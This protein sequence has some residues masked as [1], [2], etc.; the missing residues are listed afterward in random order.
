MTR[1]FASGI[2][3]P[4]PDLGRV[5][6]DGIFVVLPPADLAMVGSPLVGTAALR[7]AIS[8]GGGLAVV[9][10]GGGL[11]VVNVP[12]A[13]ELETP[14]L[15]SREVMVVAVLV[16]GFSIPGGGASRQGGRVKRR[17]NRGSTAYFSQWGP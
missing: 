15:P 17:S 9:N 10:V 13:I 5:L 11:A 1:C 4:P 3:V 16:V 14:I 12:A 8:F 6:P 2:R 7:R